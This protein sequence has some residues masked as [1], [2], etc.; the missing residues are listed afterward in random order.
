MTNDVA[1]ISEVGRRARR[2]IFRRTMPFIFLLF[3]IAYLDRVNVSY[4][5]LTM[6]NE[7]GFTQK[8]APRRWRCL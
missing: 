2:R 8:I 6:I 5:K 4:A 3:V 1:Q 7:L